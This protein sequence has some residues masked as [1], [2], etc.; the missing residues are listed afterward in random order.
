M[1]QLVNQH[2][3]LLVVAVA[4]TVGWVV[5]RRAWRWFRRLALLAIVG[6]LVAG[7][8]LL[9]TGTGD[10]AAAQDVDRALAQGRPVLVHFF[11]NY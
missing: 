5:L 1:R 7:F 6:V 3:Y 4:L 10:V 9:R 8:V 11:S 2:S